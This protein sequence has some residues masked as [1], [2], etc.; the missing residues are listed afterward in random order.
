MW[1]PQVQLAWAWGMLPP[2]LLLHTPCAQYHAP[3]AGVCSAPSPT[4]TQRVPAFCLLPV[5]VEYGSRRLRMRISRLASQVRLC[6]FQAA[7]DD[8][9]MWQEIRRQC[10]VH[11]R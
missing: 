6:T 9:R 2:V 4:G 1:F 11:V 7:H 5:V 10:P 3:A 8:L